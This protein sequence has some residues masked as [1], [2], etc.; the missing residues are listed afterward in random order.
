LAGLSEQEKNKFR[1]F[2]SKNICELHP[3]LREM[4]DPQGTPR[5]HA[6]LEA[7]ERARLLILEA[8]RP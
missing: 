8:L 7:T 3:E 2:A 6:L 1:G 5:L 4:I